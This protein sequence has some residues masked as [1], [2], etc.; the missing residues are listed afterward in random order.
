MIPAV[1]PDDRDLHVSLL[2]DCSVGSNVA[3]RVIFHEVIVC[4]N[5]VSREV[6]DLWVNAICDAV[7]P[8]IVK[9]DELLVPGCLQIMQ[10]PILSYL[11]SAVIR[12]I[13][14]VSTK[15]ASVSTSVGIQSVLANNT[16]V[17][18]EIHKLTPISWAIQTVLS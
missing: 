7:E 2:E 5:S 4:G 9:S 8:V 1:S 17:H 10:Y 14:L 13:F 6:V 11:G 18:C 3:N 12:V 15:H 16:H